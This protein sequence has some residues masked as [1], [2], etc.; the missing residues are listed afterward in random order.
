MAH[1]DAEMGHDEA[2]EEQQDAD[3]GYL[4]ILTPS[5]D[6][7]VSE[8]LLRQVGGGYQREARTA[9]R[10]IVS[11]IYSPPRVTEL[12][13]KIRRRY[14]RLVPGY[15]LDLTTNDPMDGKPWDFTRE[16]KRERARQLLRKQKPHLL[17][18]SPAC[19]A[20]C[21]LQFLN[22]FKSSNPD[23]VEKHRLEAVEHIKVVVSLYDEQMEHGRYF[24][25]EHP[26]GAGSWEFLKSQLWRQ[27]QA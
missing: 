16:D 9:S 6:D 10:K 15:A 18:G 8:F 24:L 25:H 4:C 17:I 13:G 21:T 27:F 3:M 20:F 14:R 7:E 5:F 11:E 26:L 22:A 23:A 12:L 1:G 2:Q 19:R